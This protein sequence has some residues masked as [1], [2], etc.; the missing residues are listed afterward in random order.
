M[1]QL[2]RGARPPRAQWAGPPRPTRRT[3]FRSPFGAPHTPVFGARARRTGAEAA[4]LPIQFG[5]APL[6]GG[7]GV[8]RRELIRHGAGI[9]D[10]LAPLR[11]V[12]FIGSPQRGLDG[13]EEFAGRKGLP[14]DLATDLLDESL[15]FGVRMMTRHEQKTPAQGRLHTL[16]RDIE[17]VPWKRR[18][19]HVA[20][21]QIEILNHD[22]AQSFHAVFHL[23]H[24]AGIGFQERVEGGSQLLIVLQH[25]DAEPFAVARGPGW[26][27]H[28]VA[29]VECGAVGLAVESTDYC[30]G[31]DGSGCSTPSRIIFGVTKITSS[32]FWLALNVPVKSLPSHGMSPRRGIFFSL[33]IFCVWIRPPSTMVV[34]SRTRTR[35]DACF[36]SRSGAVAP[37]APPPPPPPPPPPV[38]PV[39]KVWTDFRLVSTGEMSKEIQSSPEICGVRERM[40]PMVIELTN[41]SCT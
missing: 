16:H 27:G 38:P 30:A 6:A 5:L 26:G 34:P 25:Q 3:Q 24:G 31:T 4:A 7:R 9:G 8:G 14:Q 11:D 37:V 40:V 39:E 36:V 19:D 17:F 23:R 41:V 21:H 15:I 13:L 33:L 18:H 2:S 10:G 29:C 1:M 22:Q 32:F 35:V 28:K 12:Q 20:E